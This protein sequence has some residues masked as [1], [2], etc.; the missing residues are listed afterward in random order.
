MREIHTLLRA[1]RPHQGIAQQIPAARPAAQSEQERAGR[2]EAVPVL[3][4]LHHAYRRVA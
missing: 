3:G 2:V 4:G 1:Y